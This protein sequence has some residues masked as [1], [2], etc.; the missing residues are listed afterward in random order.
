MTITS[1]A[2]HY[3]TNGCGENMASVFDTFEESDFAESERIA[4]FTLIGSLVGAIYLFT[5]M[6]R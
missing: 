4:R 6:F 1:D 5:T 2:R 3:T